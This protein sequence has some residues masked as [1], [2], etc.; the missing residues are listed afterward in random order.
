MPRK[1]EE[2]GPVA[3]GR[4]TKCFPHKHTQVRVLPPLPRG[5]HGRHRKRNALTVYGIY[6]ITGRIAPELASIICD[7]DC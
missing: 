4:R 7:G 3:S 6:R 2:Y 1:C 5:A